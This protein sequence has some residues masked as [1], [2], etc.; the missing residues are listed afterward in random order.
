[1]ASPKQ[2]ELFRRLTEDR[3]LG[4]LAAMPA[5][6]EKFSNLTDRN[7]SAWIERALERPKRDDGDSD[8]ANVPAPF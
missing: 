6:R 3:D 7:C 2:I 8:A 5:L 4:P 1:M